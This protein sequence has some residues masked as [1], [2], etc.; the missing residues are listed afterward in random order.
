M[1][2][3]TRDSSVPID[4]QNQVPQLDRQK[5]IYC[6][7]ICYKFLTFETEIPALSLPTDIRPPDTSHL[8][9]P[10]KWSPVNES[11]ITGVSCISTLFV[12]F[13]ASCYNPGPCQMVAEWHAGE[14]AILTGITTFTSGFAV[15]PRVLA[16][17][18]E[19]HG[20]KHVFIATA[21]RYEGLWRSVRS[22]FL[23]SSTGIRAACRSD[24]Q[25]GLWLSMDRYGLSLSEVQNV[26]VRAMSEEEI[27]YL[28]LA[29]WD[30]RKKAQDQPFDGRTLL[31]IFTDLPR[32]SVCVGA[33]G[34][35]MSAQQAADVLKTGC[36]SIVIGKAAILDAD[37]PRQPEIPRSIVTCH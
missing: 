3:M 10:Y 27:D 11:I 37:F 24:F 25:I 4:D 6:Q 30:C 9:S 18:S 23:R 13:A 2:G 35:V 8:G 21:Y 22:C 15:G 16:S 17:F 20:R 26:A 7:P 14:V 5:D 1:G 12:S 19:I 36:D 33:S 32:S 28:D 29:V 34:H 31:D